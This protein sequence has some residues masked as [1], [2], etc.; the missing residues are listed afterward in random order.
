MPKSLQQLALFTTLS[1]IAWSLPCVLAQS[2]LANPLEATS[3]T[4]FLQKPPQDSTILSD[5]RSEVPDSIAPDERFDPTLDFE[6]LLADSFAEMPVADNPYLSCP[7]STSTNDSIA[8]Q[9]LPTREREITENTSPPISCVANL[10]SV[11]T[12]VDSLKTERGLATPTF[13][14]PITQENAQGNALDSPKPSPSPTTSDTAETSITDKSAPAD[15]ENL[16]KAAQNPIASL[17]SLPFQYNFNFGIGPHDR[18][19]YILNVQPVIPTSL[20]DDWLLVSRIITPILLQPIGTDASTFGLG[21][22]N[23]TF[24]FVPKVP[25]NLNWGIG[26]VLLLPTATDRSLGTGK[27]GIGPSAV[28]VWSPGQWVI[29]AL[30]N[31]IWSV[32]G[33]SSRPDVSQFLFQPFINYNLPD[34][35]YLSFAPIITA[36]WNAS[37]GNQWTVPLGGGFGRV[38][39]IDKQPVN[40]SL[41]AFWNAIK[42]EFGADWQIRFQF[43][44]LFPGGG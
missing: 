12:S 39:R 27:W 23:P 22:L 32:A 14:S 40:V 21:D 9:P 10:T 17:I 29:G 36:N 31:Q 6:E 13:A 37:A 19:Q 2:A 11:L 41:V 26:P 38:F 3:P 20:S 25:G 34:G 16:A 33:D 24:F 30:A 42:P 7:T 18:T 8:S 44:L 35:W 28:V 5:R 15:T 1:Q 4:N 43:T